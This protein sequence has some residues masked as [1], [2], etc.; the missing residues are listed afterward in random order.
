[1]L[2]E[3]VESSA[4]DVVLGRVALP[5]LVFQVLCNCGFEVEIGGNFGG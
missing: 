2:S 1:M 3:R 5:W 4:E